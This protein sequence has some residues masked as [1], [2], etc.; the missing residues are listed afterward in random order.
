MAARKFFVGG[1]WKMNGSK[2]SI[3]QL[4]Q[5]LNKVGEK[6]NIDIVVAPPTI[7]L[8]YVKQHAA[9]GIHVA[10]QNCYKVQELAPDRIKPPNP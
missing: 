5:C 3:T 8:D 7:Y 9:K 2:E 10:A 4:V 1:N 6:P